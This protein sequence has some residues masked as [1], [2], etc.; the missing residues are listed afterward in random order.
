MG[1]SATSETIKQHRRDHILYIERAKAIL[2]EVREGPD[3]KKT[4]VIGWDGGGVVWNGSNASW[5]CFVCFLRCSSSSHSLH[6]CML[7]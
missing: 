4:S 7:G 6:I 5:D 3:I 2:A 1:E